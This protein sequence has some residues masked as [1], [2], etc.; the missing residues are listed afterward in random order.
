M[1]FL[2]QLR[3]SDLQS[4]LADGDPAILSQ[5][6]QGTAA[7]VDGFRELLSLTSPLDI[8]RLFAPTKV[9]DIT[10]IVDAIDSLADFNQQLGR[11]LGS[12]TA[13]EPIHNVVCDI[14]R[15][16][17]DFSSISRNKPLSIATQAVMHQCSSP[18]ADATFT[19]QGTTSQRGSGSSTP[20]TSRRS[21][22]NNNANAARGN[23]AWQ[24]NR[25]QNRQTCH[26]FQRD[27]CTRL[28][29]IYIHQCR[30][31]GS[32]DHGANACSNTT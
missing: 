17:I 14:L 29:C 28:N 3:I 32:M 24:Q 25:Q 31:C 12:H 20:S 4:A 30:K 15:S 11:Y 1:E 7:T 26:N 5:I 27:T 6:E 21:R 9:E 8:L 2:N 18:D 10:N 13:L 23:G 16:G 19:K 22:T